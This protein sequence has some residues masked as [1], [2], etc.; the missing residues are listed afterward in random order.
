M[1]LSTLIN[2]QWVFND[3]IDL[4]ELASY[5]IDFCD[6]GAS[7][8]YFHKL[9]IENY[10]DRLCLSFYSWLSPGS[11][12][13]N[14]V[15]YYTN[16]EYKWSSKNYKSIFINGGEDAQNPILISWIESNATQHSDL[17]YKAP[18]VSIQATADALRTIR[19]ENRTYSWDS[20]KGFSNFISSIDMLLATI[21]STAAP[22][23]I[24]ADKTAYSLRT[25]ITGTM[26]NANG[27]SF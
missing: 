18:K 9:S 12:Y 23:D 2:T 19:N 5:N 25:K 27:V 24:V 14:M 4:E 6:I 1:S 8:G 22:C 13:R 3:I 15:Y 11:E 20:E 10:Q 21:D 17:I 16:G 26:L 7:D